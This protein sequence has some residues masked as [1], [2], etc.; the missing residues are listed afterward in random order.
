MIYSPLFP[1]NYQIRKLKQLQSLIELTVTI[2]SV[3]KGPI[4]ALKLL[5][6]KLWDLGNSS[7]FPRW[8]IR[9]LEHSCPPLLSPSSSKLGWHGVLLVIPCISCSVPLL[10]HWNGPGAHRGS[11]N[12][13]LSLISQM[14]FVIRTDLLS[15]DFLSGRVPCGK[16]QD[17][18]EV[19]TGL[20]WPCPFHLALDTEVLPEGG[21]SHLL[22]NSG[23]KCWVP[24]L[25]PIMPFQISSVQ[26]G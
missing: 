13:T 26:K 7:D 6:I 22:V 18:L 10:W 3:S 23:Q 25:L 17:Y 16:K 9:I 4:Y 20:A 5:L 8:Q 15:N 12:P 19:S 11:F 24:G 1:F 14:N 21:G 2:I